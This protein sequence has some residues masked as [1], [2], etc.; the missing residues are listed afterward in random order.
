MAVSAA[1]IRA[2]AKYDAKAY[3]R[4]TV[5]VPKAIEPEVNK[6]IEEHGS[7]NGY[8]LDLIKKD[9]GIQKEG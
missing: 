4:M 6:K 8:L 9:L 1:H 3:T 7:I 5:R 2:T